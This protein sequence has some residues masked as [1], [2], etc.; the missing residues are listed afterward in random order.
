MF[1]LICVMCYI[2]TSLYVWAVDDTLLVVPV[3]E[4]NSPY[5]DYAPVFIDSNLMIF[6]SSRSNPIVEKVMADNHNIY[7][8]QKE[9]DKWSEPKF[10]SY[11]ANSD[12]HET[13]A[14]ISSDRK[15]IFIYK[16]FYGG[17]LYS[18]DINGQVLSPPK[19]LDVNSSYH[20]SSVCFCKGTLFFVSDRPGGKGGHDI[21]YCTKNNDGK[22][23]K[24]NNLD[25]VNTNQDENYL[26]ITE[27]GNTLYFSSKGH[28]SKGGYD[29][30]KSVKKAN[31][32]WSEPINM[33]TQINSSY[34]EICFAKDLSGKM[35]FSSDRPDEKNSGYNIYCCIEIKIRI[36]VPLELTGN[37]QL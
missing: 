2:L 31:E 12:N 1:R 22:W 13:T 28:D 20:E 18:S 32:Q 34:N 16:S 9:K 17:D 36:K 25:V 15:T 35:Y 6:T 29:V 23:L 11:Q 37:S 3:S 24:P 14:G 26:Y 19:K 21:Y 10:V 27:D 7:I 30:F 5:D 8:S 4:I 33:G